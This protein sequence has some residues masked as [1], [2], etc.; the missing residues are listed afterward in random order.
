MFLIVDNV[1]ESSRDEAKWYTSIASLPKNSYVLVTSRNQAILEYVLG[2][3]YCQPFPALDEKE[4]TQLFLKNALSSDTP[5]PD[6]E[7]NGEGFLK[8]FLSRCSADGQFIPRLLAK[9][10]FI[11]KGRAKGAISS[12]VTHMNAMDGMV[13]DAEYERLDDT[14]KLI[15]LDLAVFARGL[16]FT[17]IGECSNTN[18]AVEFIAMLHRIPVHAA[19]K[20]VGAYSWPFLHFVC[21]LPWFLESMNDLWCFTCR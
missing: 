1:W 9:L 11:L 7:L 15:F 21:P 18:L 16:R 3:R 4:A 20:K 6:N 19:E 2:R 8:P 17:H 14:S 13:L 10:G 5:C 12:W